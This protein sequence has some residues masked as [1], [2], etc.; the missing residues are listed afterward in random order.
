MQ[1]ESS[2]SSSD[3]SSSS[4][5]GSSSSDSETSPDDELNNE[6]LTAVV[7]SRVNIFPTIANCIEDSRYDSIE[8]VPSTS[9]STANTPPSSLNHN[10]KKFLN[11]FGA[12][13]ICKGNEILFYAIFPSLNH[14]I[15]TRCLDITD[16]SIRTV[17][18]KKKNSCGMLDLD[19]RENDKVELKEKFDRHLTEKDLSRQNKEDDKRFTPDN[20]I[21][22]VYDFQAAM[23]CPRGDASNFYNVSKLNTYN[24][25][26]CDI[27]SKDTAFYVWHEG[28]AKRGATEI[29]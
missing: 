6:R 18:Q 19:N 29:G 7:Q 24:F 10:A 14:D 23:P 25:T 16:A 15:H 26:I 1:T 27:K 13:E 11:D 20:C 8:P 12:W 21:V 5:G 3:S 4:S 9:R 2:S 22:L 17:L 28:E